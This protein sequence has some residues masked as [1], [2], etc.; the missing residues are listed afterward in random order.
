MK[1]FAWALLLLAGV[2]W[3]LASASAAS[4]PE[5]VPDVDITFDRK[6]L[7]AGLEVFTDICMGCHSAKYLTYQNLMDY[8]SFGL[9]REVVDALRGERRLLS[10]LKSTLTPGMAKL[11]YGRVPPD[12]SLMA[13]AR[14]AGGAYI[15]SLLR[16]Y[17]HDPARR[18]PDEAYNIYF[19]GRRIAMP[20]PLNWLGRKPENEAA[21]RERARVVASFLV[22]VAEPRQS[23]RRR[24]GF[25]VIGYLLLLVGVLYLLVREDEKIVDS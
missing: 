4:D 2:F 21:I 25:W 5:P 7:R 16:G 13:R 9:S 11:Y 17:E 3:P 20:D 15:A 14:D 18:I 8:E 6:T 23:E 19:P 22:F 10:G 12:L 24:I 1:R